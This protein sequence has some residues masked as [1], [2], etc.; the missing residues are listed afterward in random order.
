[1]AE[2]AEYLF[3]KPLSFFMSVGYIDHT[4]LSNSF[5]RKIHYKAYT[6]Y[7]RAYRAHSPLTEAK[8][9]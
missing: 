7:T 4:T 2:V 6:N 1:M 5:S 3:S 9:G 8:L